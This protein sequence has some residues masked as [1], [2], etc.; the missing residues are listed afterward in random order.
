MNLAATFTYWL[1]VALWLAVFV[2]LCASYL[3][4]PKEF[5]AMRLLLAVLLIDTVRNLSENLYFGIYWGGR[6]G[7]FPEWTSV[8]GDPLYLMAMK[9]L[10]VIA[11]VAVLFVLAIRWLPM[12]TRE[13]REAEEEIR[14]KEQALNQEVEERR[15]LFDNSVDMIIIADSSGVFRRVSPS[16]AETLGYAP[17]DLT[18][19]SAADLICEQDLD[20]AYSM[21]RRLRETGHIRNFECRCRHSDGRVVPTDWSGVWSKEEQRFYF[22]GRDM[23]E[24]MVA[25][26]RLKH[27]ALNDPLTGLGNRP[28]LHED[29]GRLLGRGGNAVTAIAMLD[30]DGFKDINDTLGH[31]VG[32]SLLQA[33]SARMLEANDGASFYRLGGDEFVLVLPDCGDPLVI[34]GVVDRLLERLAERFSVDDHKLLVTASAGIAIAPNDGST[35]DELV[36]SADLALYDAKADGGRCC[37]LFIPQLRI[38]AEARRNL[39][40]ELRQAVSQNE[41]ELYFQPQIRSRDGAV[42]G[43]EALLRWRHPV[44]GLLTPAA[45]IGALADSPSAPELG[46]W[47][48]T[49]ACQAAASWRA[50][51]GSGP[52]VAV[53]LFP[54]QFRANTLLRDVEYA[55]SASGLPASGLELEITENIALERDDSV[56]DPLVQLRAKGVGIA[57]DD[58][59]TGYASLSCLTRY[60]LTRIKIDR[61]FV[62]NMVDSSDSEGTAI[63]RSIIAMAGNLGLDVTAEGVETAAQATFLR[64]EG[65]HDLQGY[66][67]SKPMPAESFRRFLFEWRAANDRLPLTGSARSA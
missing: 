44:H 9:G 6:Y 22:I 1:I 39:E 13:W 53:N 24:Q 45:F 7:V 27:L 29:L 57:F 61:S 49:A 59:G 20:E 11:A 25:E 36:S 23:T 31:S 19:R 48:L 62:A 2:T 12:A 32:D 3:R 21:L 33:V 34:S 50:R 42:A 38:R 15:R 65:C 41:F 46:R 54:A 8:L 37:R 67:F 64:A 43:A 5:G 60:P 16:V 58:F 10:T 52:T 4:N 35:V 66:V 40:A 17:S 63:V 14:R 28:R 30:L 56:L 51:D 26:D 18:G 47:I 55:L